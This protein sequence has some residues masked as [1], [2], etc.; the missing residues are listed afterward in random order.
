[1]IFRSLIFISSFLLLNSQSVACLA[2]AWHLADQYPLSYRYQILS[3]ASQKSEVTEN[4]FKTIPH[5]VSALFVE[6]YAKLGLKIKVNL[7]WEKPFFTAWANQE[8]ENSFS[9]NFW[10]GLARIPSM[11]KDSFALVA[12]HEI[13]HILGGAPKM[14]ISS[15]L[16]A[17]SEGQSDYFA[18]GVCLKRYLKLTTKKQEHINTLASPTLYTQCRL[19]FSDDQDFSICLKAGNAALA[20]SKALNYLSEIDLGIDLESQSPIQV[21]ETLFNSYPD[22]QCRL[23]TLVAGALCDEVDFPCYQQFNQRPNCWFAQD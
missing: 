21:S 15:F 23:D 7:D 2:H 13:G 20:F 6:D 19:T 9:I 11:T 8:S 17:T 12:C 10:G 22:V 14:K 16:W 1:M 4:N 3:D 18:T 5:L